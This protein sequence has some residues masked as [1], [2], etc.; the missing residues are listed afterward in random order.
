M[1]E[2]RRVRWGWGMPWLVLAALGCGQVETE[3]LLSGRSFL[4]ER[5]EGFEPVPESTI[6]IGFEASRVRFDAGCN[7]MGGPYSIEDG[8]LVIHGLASTMMGC[9]PLAA[10]EDWYQG[11]VRSKP[12]LDLDGDRLTLTGETATLYYLDREVADPD[13]PL[14]GPTWKVDA[15][16]HDLGAA[17]YGLEKAPWFVFRDDGSLE[18]FAGCNTGQGRYEVD[19]GEL[20]FSKVGYTKMACADASQQRAEDHM[21]A[22][23]AEGT[24]TYEIEAARI[25]IRRGEDG[26]EAGTE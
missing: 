22:V 10:Q 18:V 9:G 14:V 6:R 2:S 16:L 24:V 5:A 20:T 21:V 25:T 23:F 15:F 1:R 4:L 19:G 17:H 7:Q 26:V 3:D 12:L 11:F 13:R 8:R